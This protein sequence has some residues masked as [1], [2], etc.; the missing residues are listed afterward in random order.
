VEGVTRTE[1]EVRGS[2]YRAYAAALS[3]ALAELSEDV[4][5]AI[6]ARGVGA[7]SP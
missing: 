2:G 6:R 4:A 7:A 3:S 5:A 1:R